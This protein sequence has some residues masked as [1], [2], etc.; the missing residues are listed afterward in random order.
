MWLRFLQ[1]QCLTL[2]KR[3]FSA[4][5]RPLQRTRCFPDYV[6]GMVCSW[7]SDLWTSTSSVQTFLL[8]WC[9]AALSDLSAMSNALWKVQSCS[10]SKRCCRRLLQMPHTNRSGSIVLSESRDTDSMVTAAPSP[11]EGG[12]LAIGRTPKLQLV[13]SV[14]RA[15]TLLVVWCVLEARGSRRSAHELI[16]VCARPSQTNTNT[17]YWLTTLLFFVCSQI[18]E[19][20]CTFG[21]NRSFLFAKSEKRKENLRTH[22]LRSDLAQY[23]VNLCGF[24]GRLSGLLGNLDTENLPSQSSFASL[25]NTRQLAYLW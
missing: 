4:S 25:P 11:F 3:Q 23:L 10:A 8:S 13:A 21:R 5:C 9:F 22:A 17:T 14:F 12:V 1:Y 2:R 20:Q 15:A 16:C 19:W 7:P 24:G 18:Y 6:W